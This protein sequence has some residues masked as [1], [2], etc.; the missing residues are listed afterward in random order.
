MSRL[1]YSLATAIF[2]YDPETG[3]LRW[4]TRSRKLFATDREWR[5][6]NARWSGKEAFTSHN[7]YGLRFG[8]VL[9]EIH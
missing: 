4:N 6:F 1:S 8:W 3:S 7:Q 5:S 2:N 9:G